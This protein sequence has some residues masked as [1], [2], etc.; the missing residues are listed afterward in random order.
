MKR[1]LAISSLV[2]ALAP[3]AMAQ[4]APADDG[5]Y[6]RIGGGATFVSDIDQNIALNP[7]GAV[8]AAIGCNADRQLIESDP[9]FIAS[10]AIGFDYADGIR[11]ELEYRFASSK[12]SR[13]QTFENGLEGGGFGVI[14]GGSIVDPNANAH[15]VLSNFYFDFYN[16][17]PITPFIGGGVGGA[18]VAFGEGGERDAALAYQGRAGVSVSLGGGFL[19]DLEYVYLRTNKLRYGP[20]QEDFTPAGPFEAA[21]FDG[22]YESS[23]AMLSLRKPF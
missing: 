22:R 7:A 11:T 17:S 13:V 15:F 12:I 1:V 8:C 16:Q 18:F 6:I 23:S 19:A 14:G 5:P 21:V 10:G 2:L 3:A 20:N 9:G 4:N